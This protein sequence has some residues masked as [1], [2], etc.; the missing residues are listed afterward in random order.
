MDSSNSGTLY[1]H[2]HSKCLLFIY[3]AQL[4]VGY[5][6]LAELAPHYSSPHGL[7][8]KYMYLV[9]QAISK[10]I[11]RT[12]YQ[13]ECSFRIFEAGSWHITRPLCTIE[14]WEVGYKRRNRTRFGDYEL[15]IVI[16]S[17]ITPPITLYT[18]HCLSNEITI[19]GC[20]LL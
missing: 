7:K 14:D 1:Y 4:M 16:Y 11:T 3:V 8:L 12:M 18:S 5:P 2:C 17:N 10:A 13:L 15:V 6:I 20:L 19:L 9:K